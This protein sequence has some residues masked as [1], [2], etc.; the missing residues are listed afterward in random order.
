MRLRT[1]TLLLHYAFSNVSHRASFLLTP[2]RHCNRIR[3]ERGL[4]HA[5][6]LIHHI[7]ININEMI[8]SSSLSSSSSSSIEDVRVDPDVEDTKERV[9]MMSDGD[10][11]MTTYSE[12]E[13]ISSDHHAGNSY[14]KVERFIAIG[15][16]GDD[17]ADAMVMAVE[18]VLDEPIPDASV[19]KRVSSM[20]RYIS[21]NIGPVQ[22]ISRD[23][24]KAVYEA[25]MKDSRLKFFF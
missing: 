9:K 22:L 7:N 6:R 13:T 11:M 16:G 5:K 1:T 2:A 12:K 10:K 25:M 14:P 19:K 24:V 15:S 8:L 23:Q 17:F 3:C 4:L 20:G 18:S 21:V